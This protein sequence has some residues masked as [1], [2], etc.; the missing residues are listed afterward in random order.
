MKIQKLKKSSFLCLLACVLAFA[1]FFVG[2]AI[3]GKSA[4]A[5][6]GEFESMPSVET[7][8]PVQ[9]R[10]TY[11]F[12][13]ISIVSKSGIKWTIKVENNHTSNITFVYNSKMCF[14]G[15]ARDWKNLSHVVVCP[16][17]L[18]PGSSVNVEI[19]ENVFAAYITLS[20][21]DQGKRLV[22]YANNLKSGPK[23]MSVYNH[24]I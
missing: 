10:A 2:T 9:T 23:T 14:Q 6:N 16:T 24:A 19:Q 1:A 18:T 22:T 7:E 15:D 5:H 13:D 21:L 3:T 12:L 11:Y 17:E 20:W 8:N 4:S